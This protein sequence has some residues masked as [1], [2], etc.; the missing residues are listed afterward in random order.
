[1]GRLRLRAY[2]ALAFPWICVKR[3]L[4]WRALGRPWRSPVDDHVL[5]GGLLFPGDV[6]DL[7][8][9]GVRAV[10][11]LCAEFDDPLDRLRA[12]GIE[13]L[14]L[15]TPDLTPPSQEDLTRAVA[16]IGERASRG[17]RVYVHCAS[18]VGRSATVAACWLVR[19]GRTPEDALALLAKAR[20]AVSLRSAQVR[21]VRS[22]VVARPV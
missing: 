16:F 10:V 6:A 15:P 9:E 21:A 18:G 19:Q 11:S 1:M 17:E 14:H 8:R 2:A 3:F 5:L 22:F 12:A 4:V 20:P 7:S 13:H